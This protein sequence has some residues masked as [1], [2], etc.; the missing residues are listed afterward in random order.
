MMTQ[1][2]TC[3]RQFGTYFL[4]GDLYVKSR[5]VNYM[6]LALKRVT[7]FHMWIQRT[8]KLFQKILSTSLQIIAA[9]NKS[10]KVYYYFDYLAF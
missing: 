3:F 9:T 10:G 2:Q 4:E 5:V 6:T 7:I 1:S 8:I